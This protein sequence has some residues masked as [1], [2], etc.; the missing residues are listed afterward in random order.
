MNKFQNV[1][2]PKLGYYTVGNCV[3][4]NKIE[5]VFYAASTHQTINWIF[6]NHE[7]STFN[8]NIEP[9]ESLDSLYDLRARQ[10]REKYGYLVLMYSGGTDS[11]NIL[12]S[13]LRQNLP[14]DELI[15]LSSDQCLRNFKVPDFNDR[16]PHNAQYSEHILQTLP[17][18]QEIKNNFPKI[19]IT[20]EDT[21]SLIL[22]DYQT[23]K[24]GDWIKSRA[25][26]LKPSNVKWTLDRIESFQKLVNDKSNIGIILGV[27]KPRTAFD[28]ENNFFIIF[29]DTPTT[30]G[31]N[32]VLEQY[33]NTALEFFY[34]DPD[35]LKLL[36]KQAH[37]IKRYIE[38]NPQL[39]DSWKLPL[40]KEKLAWVHEPLLRNILYGSTWNEDK[41][42]QALKPTNGWVQDYDAWF[43]QNDVT[44]LKEI[45]KIWKRGIDYVLKNSQGFISYSDNKPDGL[46]KFHSKYLVGK[47]NTG[48]M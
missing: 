31:P 11:H 33:S 25:E 44:E 40:T 42:Y 46:I 6:N 10:L 8:W 9:T 12:C 22:E 2:Q 29:N 23:H 17:R 5:A 7:F 26:W 18:L 34:W 41:Y 15:V 48:P 3:F 32:L 16:S 43:F 36:S 28:A 19:K 24:D 1:K 45:Q 20:L 13:F 47:F 39:H 37:V 21:S 35:C 30:F 14:I 4:T 27:E 38:L